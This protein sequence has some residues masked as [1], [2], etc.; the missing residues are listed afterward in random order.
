MTELP[1]RER[2]KRTIDNRASVGIVL[3]YREA[4]MCD[5][6]LKLGCRR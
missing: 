4:I 2:H 3:E 6:N 1:C 5:S